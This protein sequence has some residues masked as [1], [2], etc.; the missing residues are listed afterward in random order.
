MP[1]L[2]NQ[3]LEDIRRSL[4]STTPGASAV[5]QFAGTKSPMQTDTENKTLDPKG[6]DSQGNRLSAPTTVYSGSVLDRV[7]SNNLKL[8]KLSNTGT[9]VNEAGQAVYSDGTIVPETPTATVETP[10]ET[11]TALA[12]VKSRIAA[13][14]AGTDPTTKQMLDTIHAQYES[15]R[16]EQDRINQASEKARQTSLLM[17]GT[18]RY[19]PLSATGIQHAQMS[20]GL[21]QIQDLDIAEQQAINSAKQAQITQNWPLM[22]KELA[23]AET[24]RKEKQAAAQKLADQQAE[25]LAKER[26]QARAAMVDTEIATM[27]QGGV[28]DPIDILRKM[29]EQGANMTL[30]EVEESMTYLKESGDMEKLKM[31]AAKNNAPADLLTTKYASYGDALAKLQ[32]YLVTPQTEITKLANGD[33]VVVDKR[34][35]KIISNLGGAKPGTGTPAGTVGANVDDENVKLLEEK[36]ALIQGLKD[37]PALK[38]RVGPNAIARMSLTNWATGSADAFSAKVSQ[39]TSRETLDTLINLKARGGTL[40]ALSDQERTMLQ[41]AASAIGGLEIKDKNG[42]GTGYYRGSEANFRTELD[43]LLTVT[44]RAL[45]RARGLTGTG[46]DATENAKLSAAFPTTETSTPATSFDESA[47]FPE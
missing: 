10:T 17:G 28:T 32:P 19:A 18:A 38:S 4:P 3:Q 25:A 42:N 33:S 2:T 30:K 21:A 46:F 44:N 34:T 22:E 9:S 6:Y 15:R 47:Y 12:D 35:G 41:N 43:K 23:N 8:Q 39:L 14:Q 31:E 27:Y 24:K 1:T 16:Q 20:Y 40:G 29:N 13:I 37:D 11:D 36:T 5:T 26:D 45:E 7:P